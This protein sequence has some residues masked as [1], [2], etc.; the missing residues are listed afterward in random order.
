[1]YVR[2]GCVSEVSVRGGGGRGR[3]RPERGSTVRRLVRVGEGGGKSGRSA[4]GSCPSRPSSPAD[5]WLYL[6]I[7]PLNGLACPESCVWSS[8]GTSPHDP[9]VGAQ[10]G[11]TLGTTH[12]HMR[13]APE[14]VAPH[15]SN[16]AVF[17]ACST[18]C[19]RVRR[20]CWTARGACPPRRPRLRGWPPTKPWAPDHR[21]PRRQRRQQ[22]QLVCMCRTP[23]AACPMERRR[24]RRQS[25]GSLALARGVP[26]SR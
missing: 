25:T 23:G 7:G 14:L 10:T 26:L 21:P 8:R 24:C 4:R 19:P 11:P 17:D 16:T 3:A 20:G 15:P 22:P 2:V 9:G 1:M 6:L 13:R 12:T 5:R 18:L